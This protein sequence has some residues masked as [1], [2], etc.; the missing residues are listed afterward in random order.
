MPPKQSQLDLFYQRLDKSYSKRVVVA[1]VAPDR[2]DVIP[3]GSKVL[4][5]A[6]YFG[7]WV[8]GRIHELVGPP[9]ASKTTLMMNTAAN[10]QAKWPKKLV[11]YVGMEK[12]LYDD[13]A[14]MNGVDLSREHWV[15]LKP[16]TAEQASDMMRDLCQSNMCSLVILD[17]V[18]GMESVKALEK[19]AKDPLPGANAQVVTRMCKNLGTLAW[20]TDTT[21]ILVNQ[22]RAI[23]GAAGGNVS[24]GPYAM[25]H[26]TTTRVQISRAGGNESH[27]DLVMEAGEDAETVSLQFR[28]RVTRSKIFP[29][30]RKAEYWVNNRPTKE[31]GPAGINKIDQYSVMAIRSGFAVKQ[32]EGSWYEVAGKRVNGRRAVGELLRGSEEHR[33]LMDDFMFAEA[34][35]KAVQADIDTG[36]PL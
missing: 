5:H 22:L 12:T 25:Q 4:D 36:R 14:R 35:A 20:E 23:I 16:G 18:G 2:Y 6:L 11:G 32:G 24:A 26:S 34:R 27:A 33:K 31:Y 30:G 9:D 15:H 21:I 10:A 19:D 17:S 7:G 13:W 8:K 1:N 3:T 28:A 29:P